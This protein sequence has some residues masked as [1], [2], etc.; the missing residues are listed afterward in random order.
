MARVQDKV[1]LI[2]GASGGIGSETARLLAREGAFVILS[3]IRDAAGEALAREIGDRA[4][5]LHLDVASTA[6]WQSASDA[7]RGRFGGLDILFN[8]AGVSGFESEFEDRPQNIETV[9]FDDWRQI[10]AVNLDGLF[11]GCKF[12]VAL[13]KGRGGSIINMSSRSGN[14]GIGETAGYC[15][16]KGAVRNLTKS[17]AMHCAQNGLK[18][19]CNSLHPGAIL[20]PMWD[21][22]LGDTAEQREATLAFVRRGIPLNEMGEPI[23]VAYGV[24]Y[25]ASDESR[26]LTGSEL[27]IDGGI[28]AGTT[29]A[30]S[31][32]DV[33]D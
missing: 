20:T 12:G 31:H 18:I 29:A 7:I 28:M 33:D 23:D 22:A 5:Y 3:D 13:M 19:R 11:L 26:Y 32:V 27:V 15:S 21:R 9:S 10:H 4:L 30:P 6:D 24:L 1:A 2:T 8:C 16:S 14:V 17:V 25:L